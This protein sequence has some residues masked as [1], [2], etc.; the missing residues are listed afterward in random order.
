MG[1]N[2]QTFQEEELQVIYVDPLPLK[3]RS[4][5]LIPT[6]GLHK[7][8]FFQK[9]SGNGRGNEKPDKHSLSQC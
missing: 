3:G 2:R 1:E 6:C 4:S 8:T 5:L 9:Q 7:V